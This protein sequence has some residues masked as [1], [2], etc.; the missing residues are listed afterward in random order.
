M[1]IKVIGGLQESVYGSSCGSE[2]VTSREVMSADVCVLANA[3]GPRNIVVDGKIFPVKYVPTGIKN[4]NC[5]CF[6]SAGVTLDPDE[7]KA[8]IEYLNEAGFTNF[9][10]VSLS[11]NARIKSLKSEILEN[12]YITAVDA[13]NNGEI[14]K[15]YQLCKH[16]LSNIKQGKGLR[17][18]E[19]SHF[20]ED[21]LLTMQELDNKKKLGLDIE[22]NY[23]I[24][25]SRIKSWLQIL[26]SYVNETD[27]EVEIA[28]AI[29]KNKTIVVEAGSV[30]SQ[31]NQF[32][33]F[34]G[35]SW[36]PNCTAMGLLSSTG[37]NVGR[38]GFSVI[39][40][41]PSEIKVIDFVW[42]KY[43]AQLNGVDKIVI[44]GTPDS[45]ITE[46]QDEDTKST[47]TEYLQD[48]VYLKKKSK[49][50]QNWSK[51][52]PVTFDN[53][54]S[55]C[56]EQFINANADLACCTQVKVQSLHEYLTDDS[57]K[58]GSNYIVAPYSN[59]M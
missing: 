2:Y 25:F 3:N 51:L 31:D 45:I 5:Q 28:K 46:Y 24:I 8:E 19:L 38:R 35:K 53:K 18:F 41:I 6:I 40:V 42:S 11:A 49:D 32:G 52:Q 7:F 43:A 57:K 27:T 26:F 14:S 58:S 13:Q 50:I 29:D 56:L 4:K 1:C 36:Y 37:I 22:K 21:L 54:L 30:F 20:S 55:Q 34:D 39:G 47:V 33:Y 23:A 12:I 59:N 44:C 16:D 10:N 9:F 17:V 15:E 48:A